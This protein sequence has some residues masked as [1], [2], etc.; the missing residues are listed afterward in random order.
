MK[1]KTWLII[2]ILMSFQMGFV[3][4]NNFGK[5]IKIEGT[6]GEIYYKKGVTKEEAIKVGNYLKKE[7]YFSE[8]KP[9]SIQLTKQGEDYTVRLVY[10]KDYYNKTPALDEIFKKGGV[11]MSKELF[12]GKKVNVALADKYMKDFKT[13]PY[14]EH[15]AAELEAPGTDKT[16]GDQT[17]FNKGDYDHDS[18]GGVD[19]YWK[20]ISDSDSKMIADYIVKNGSF[21]GG[22]AEIYMSKEGERYVL[23]FP[24]KEEYQNSSDI[25]NEIEKVSKDIKDNVFPNNPYSFHITDLHLKTIKSFDY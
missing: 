8:D 17:S 19:F 21:A 15:Y 1:T 6:R 10:N 20:G 4:C 14:D 9:A 5:K 18:A 24:V 23:K 3:S 12:N 16:M 2:S 7:G 25:I 11:E 13:Y 22:T